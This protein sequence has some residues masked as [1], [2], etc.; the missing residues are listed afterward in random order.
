MNNRSI[1]IDIQKGILIFLVLIGHLFF[2]E[3]ESRTLTLIYSFHMPA[4]LII[5]G[6]LSHIK[7]DYKTTDIIKKR[8]INTLIPYFI[9]YA[10]SLL[11]LSAD[12]N[13]TRTNAVIYIFYGLGYADYAINLPLWFL[14]YYFV[15]MTAFELIDLLCIRIVEK[16]DFKTENKFLSDKLLLKQI[17]LFVLLLILATISFVYAKI[18]HGKRLIYNS[19]LALI[20]ILFVYLGKLIKI[21]IN[22]INASKEKFVNLLKNNVVKIV[23]VILFVVIAIIWYKSSLYNT[24]V[25]INAKKLNN[26]FLLYL[27]A[28][29]GYILLSVFCFIVYKIPFINKFV[30]FFGKNSLYILAYHV[31]AV[32]FINLLI[33]PS[34]SANV[35]NLLNNANVFSV[36]FFV[37]L[38]LLF[39]IFMAAIHYGIRQ[40]I[41]NKR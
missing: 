27:N 17:L 3:Y 39:S 24:R 32:M 16:I 26:I 35:L 23:I 6:L 36:L 34:L 20:S 12:D 29:L 2:F 9:F 41:N 28:I 10:I 30:A 1:Y 13:I 33:K 4:F 7:T 19:E 21:L 18:Y 40:Y 5:G 31:P 38:E 8:F 37:V 25:D 22:K 14:T 15:A 11:I